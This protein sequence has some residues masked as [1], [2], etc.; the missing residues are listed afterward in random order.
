MSDKTSG[1]YILRSPALKRLKARLGYA[2]FN[3]NTAV[4]G[5]EAVKVGIAKKPQDLAISWNP[6]D[7]AFAAAQARQFVTSEMLVSAVDAIDR[8]MIDLASGPSL[9]SQE[10]LRICL[11]R[12]A[13]PD[14]AQPQP[15]TT[16]AMKRHIAALQSL[17]EPM[18][19]LSEVKEFGDVYF[20]KRK[21]KGVRARVA[22]LG[23]TYDPEN[24][25]VSKHYLACVMLLVSWRNRYVHGA[26]DTVSV[27]DRLTLEAA[28]QEIYDAHSHCDISK[29]LT[30]YDAGRGP[31]LKDVSTLVSITHRTFAAIDAAVLSAADLEQY[32]D[33]VLASSLNSLTD[34][35]D[36]LKKYWG[37]NLLW[38]QKKIGALLVPGGFVLGQPTDGARVLMRQ[39]VSSIAE[40][41]PGELLE[42]YGL[43]HKRAS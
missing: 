42:R 18:Q 33:F 5:L 26:T 2:N 10:Y 30:H 38:R 15:L 41:S 25:I 31:S 34:G 14:D 3:L 19:F 43:T 16:S 4:V 32:A 20:Q 22:V 13:V 39:F 29:T 40:A 17:P 28:K 1:I 7:R 8:Y 11:R 24:T 9:L 27:Q 6:S 36:T 21:P 23:A 35:A 37:K 12:E